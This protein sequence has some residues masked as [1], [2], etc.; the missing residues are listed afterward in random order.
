[1]KTNQTCALFTGISNLKFPPPIEDLGGLIAYFKDQLIEH[2]GS[3]TATPEEVLAALKAMVLA[4]PNETEPNVKFALSSG[5]LNLP[6]INE[7]GV[8]KFDLRHAEKK[9]VVS[10]LDFEKE[11][12]LYHSYFQ[13]NA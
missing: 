13:G 3:P 1:M 8:V 6:A 5:W 9:I 7:S 12:E 4:E 11:I 10:D 2:I